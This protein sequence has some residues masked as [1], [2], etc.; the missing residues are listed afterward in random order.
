MASTKT[1]QVLGVSVVLLHLVNALFVGLGLYL[2]GFY[3]SGQSMNADKKGGEWA[4]YSRGVVRGLFLA[5]FIIIW[6]SQMQ[7]NVHIGYLSYRRK[8]VK[9]NAIIG[10]TTCAIAFILCG[11][12]HIYLGMTDDIRLFVQKGSAYALS[13]AGTFTLGLTSVIAVI[14]VIKTFE[15]ASPAQG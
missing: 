14:Y 12:A 15:A 9:V 13:V 10:A 7:I 5:S 1:V 8:H 4:R 3:V 6:N 11:A 2:H